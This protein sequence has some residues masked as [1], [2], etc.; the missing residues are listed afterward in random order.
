[1]NLTIVLNSKNFR[2]LVTSKYKLF[3]IDLIIRLKFSMQV[4]G[5]KSSNSGHGIYSEVCNSNDV[6]KLFE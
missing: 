1:M 2:L 3:N 5:S 6:F 4:S